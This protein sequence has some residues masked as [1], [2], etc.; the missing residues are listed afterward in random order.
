VCYEEESVKVKKERVRG[1]G[2]MHCV[3]WMHL[4]QGPQATKVKAKARLHFP[5]TTAS[6]TLVGVSWPDPD[7]LWKTTFKKKKEI[8]G[9]AR[10][11]VGGKDGESSD[12]SEGEADTIDEQKKKIAKKR[13]ED[14]LEPVFYH[15]PS[16]QL[17][18]EV[19]HLAAGDGHPKHRI[20]CVIDFTVGEGTMAVA[21]MK[22]NIPYFGL[23][24]TPAHA[25]AIEKVFSTRHLAL[26]PLQA[27]KFLMLGQIWARRGGYAILRNLPES[28]CTPR[29]LSSWRVQGISKRR[30]KCHPQADSSKSERTTGIWR[31][32]VVIGARCRHGGCDEEDL[33]GVQVGGGRALQ[34]GAGHCLGDN[35]SCLRPGG[36]WRRRKEE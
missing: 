7:T 8:F 2:S 18:E 19:L 14:D 4:V 12:E 24:L 13:G 21:T 32:A 17:M 5:G 26:N 35:G 22:H 36:R 31:P 3:E 29:S 33:A 30:A 15:A 34:A 23:C 11:A 28:S 10:V 6:D 1:V 25:E 9:D 16:L 27:S 20:R